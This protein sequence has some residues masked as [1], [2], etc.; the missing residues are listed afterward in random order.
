MYGVRP[1]RTALNEPC[2]FLAEKIVDGQMNFRPRGQI[3]FN[4]DWSKLG[5]VLKMAGELKRDAVK[6]DNSQLLILFESVTN[7]TCCLRKYK[8]S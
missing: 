2:D 8:E 6:V 3:E 5:A 4:N 1:G 7:W